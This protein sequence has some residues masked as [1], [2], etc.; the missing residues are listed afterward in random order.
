LKAI[1]NDFEHFDER[2]DDALSTGV[3]TISDWYI[4]HNGLIFAAGTKPA[5]TGQSPRGLSLRVFV[6]P[7]GLLLFGATELDLFSLDR[8]HK[9]LRQ[10][11][12]EVAEQQRGLIRGRGLFAGQRLTQIDPAWMLNR[13]RQWLAQR[14]ADGE[15]VGLRLSSDDPP[16]LIDTWQGA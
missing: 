4:A 6:P 3:A 2:L 16:R 5:G 11:I 12:H 8:G 1:R 13:F 9:A 7:A 10:S 15:S 14:D